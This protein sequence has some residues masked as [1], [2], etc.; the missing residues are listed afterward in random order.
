MKNKYL[1]TNDWI[2]GFTQSDGSF[3]ISFENKTNG[4]PIRPRPIFNLTQSI[5]ELEMFIAL[6][7]YLGVGVIQK[8]RDN[9]TLVVRSLD[10]I[11]SV[12]IP[13]FD[14]YPLRGSKLLSYKIFREITLMMKDKKHLTVDG[15]LQILDLSYFMNKET[16]LRTEFKKEELLGKLILKYGELPKFERINIPEPINL[17]PLTLEFVRGLVDGDGSF[18]ISFRMDRRRIGTN[19]TVI[20]ELSSISVLNELVDFFNCGTVYTL[21]SSAARYQVQTVD[22]ILEKIYPIFKNHP[23]NTIK[24]THFEKT[25]E[26]C[27]LI[28]VKGYKSDEDLKAIVE[29]AWDMN[30]SGK[31]RRVSKIEYLSKFIKNEK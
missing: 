16:S 1:F 3:V 15:T 22:E 8:N 6:Q 21:V 29:L 7:K 17:K 10:E 25:I 23:F 30:K 13:L 5:N 27:K 24:Q 18:N 12:L 28:K 19:F 4:I 20:T 9:V 11:I 31:G 2:S 26:V 14:N